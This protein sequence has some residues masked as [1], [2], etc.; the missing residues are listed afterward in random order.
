MPMP[1][2]APRLQDAPRSEPDG[3]P[4]VEHGSQRGLESAP[5]SPSI[6]TLPTPAAPVPTA[7]HRAGRGRVPRWAPLGISLGV[8]GILL[9][10]LAVVYASVPAGETPRPAFQSVAFVEPCLEED[11]ACEPPDLPADDPMDELELTPIPAP[12]QATPYDDA[13]LPPL[14]PEVTYDVP[15]LDTH[16]VPLTAVEPR[17]AA[18]PQPMP[19]PPVVQRPAPRPPAARPVARP[20][21]MRTR[22]TPK[23]KLVS[24]PSLMRYYPEE[25]RRRGIEGEALVEIVVDAS[26]R[27]TQATLL[28]S[29]GSDLLDRQAIR[30]M[31]AYRFEAGAGGKARVPVNFRLR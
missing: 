23:L 25:A 11:E 31:Y 10:V 13:E 18:S 8:H 17:R 2:I 28:R 24:R 9:V 19:M 20:P 21:T 4:P 3:R 1:K 5:R 30:V 14:E 27:V 12:A 22:P 29:S 6:E 15:T 7:A 26:G 16:E